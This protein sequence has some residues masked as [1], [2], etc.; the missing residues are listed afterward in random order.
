[1]VKELKAFDVVSVTRCCGE[2]VVYWRF[3]SVVLRRRG[4]GEVL[5]GWCS[6]VTCSYAVVVWLV[7]IV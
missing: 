7:L 6:V 1:M 3:V 4:G 2:G 5:A